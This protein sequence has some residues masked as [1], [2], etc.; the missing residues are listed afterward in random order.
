MK[1]NMRKMISVFMTMAVCMQVAYLDADVYACNGQVQAEEA[2]VESE[3]VFSEGNFN[4]FAK[5][6][7][8]MVAQDEIRVL[9]NCIDEF[10]TKRLVV[11]AT[12]DMTDK[13]AIDCVSGFDDLYIFQYETIE[14]VKTAYKNFSVMEEVI[15]VEPDKVV[16]GSRAVMKN[17]A[18]ITSGPAQ[19]VITT[20]EAVTASEESAYVSWGVEAMGMDAFAGRLTGE[21]LEKEIIVAVVDTG[22]NDDIS[23][24]FAD[25]VVAGTAYAQ[26]NPKYTADRHND[27]YEDDNG[28]GTMVAGIIAESTPSNVKIMPIKSLDYEGYGTELTVYMGLMHAIKEEVDVINMSLGG[29]DDARLYDDAMRDAEAKDIAVVVAAGNE[30]QNVKNVAPARIESVFTIGAI[31]SEMMV[32]DF[33]NFGNSLDFVAPGCDVELYYYKGGT[34]VE[35]GTSF[36]SPHMAAATALLLCAMPELKPS[37]LHH[38]M[39]ACAT[40]LGDKGWDMYYGYGMVDFSEVTVE[41]LDMVANPTGDADENEEVTLDDAQIVL[42]AALGIEEISVTAFRKVDM[43]L[44]DNITLTDAKRVLEIALGIN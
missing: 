44:D 4:E 21:A 7:S 43:D 32:A 41:Y 24:I 31:D 27:V 11:K 8:E 29:M 25:R 17:S 28:H 33:S 5:S 22:L 3:D 1:N 36:A 19:E 10:Q 40:D 14:A 30:A 26:V 6:V 20:S 2:V 16:T 13:T 9:E 39:K 23:D 35:D 42:C 15:Y 12:V 38:L 18:D 34:V 37:Q